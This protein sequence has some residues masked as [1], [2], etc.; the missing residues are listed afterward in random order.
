VHR[1]QRTADDRVSQQLESVG[2]KIS[3]LVKPV[4]QRAEQQQ[5]DES[6]HH[7][8]LTRATTVKL[9][10]RQL[11]D[12]AFAVV[13]DDDKDGGELLQEAPWRTSGAL[14][15]P[16]KRRC[17]VDLVHVGRRRDREIVGANEHRDVAGAE[18][19]WIPARD[20][21]PNTTVQHGDKPEPAREVM[22]VRTH[23]SQLSAGDQR[24]L[25]T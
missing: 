19:K 20:G 14:E 25:R 17:L 10:C 1:A 11:E 24:A 9:H 6:I 2:C 16:D 13:V 23:E 8:L 15:R 4:P 12:R 3:L 22:T 18:H 21:Q 7:R 5:V